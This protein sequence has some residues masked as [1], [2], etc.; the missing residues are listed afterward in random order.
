MLE[1]DV[2]WPSQ[3]GKDDV[4]ES[5]DQHEEQRQDVN[6][7]CRCYAMDND[8]QHEDFSESPA[9]NHVLGLGFRWPGMVM[10]QT[11]V[12]SPVQ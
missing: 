6:Q 8:T 3:Q 7:G 5:A 9:A 2:G 11:S 12:Y 1:A 4:D 10:V